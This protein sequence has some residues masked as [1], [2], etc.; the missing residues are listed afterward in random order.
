MTESYRIEAEQNEKSLK[1]KLIQEQSE[2]AKDV[3]D[4]TI[5]EYEKKII[6]L[7]EESDK[8][9][10]EYKQ[11]L[12]TQKQQLM[13]EI[14]Q[15]VEEAVQNAKREL[16]AKYETEMNEN[17]FANEKAIDVINQLNEKAIK[18][19][20]EE[21]SNEDVILLRKTKTPRGAETIRG[22]QQSDTSVDNIPS[23]ENSN[24]IN[25]EIKSTGHDNSLLHLHSVDSPKKVE[26]G[27]TTNKSNSNFEGENTDNIILNLSPTSGRTPQAWKGISL[28]SSTCEFHLKRN[29]NTEIIASIHSA[30]YDGEVKELTELLNVKQNISSVSKLNG[31]LIPIHRAITGLST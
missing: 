22:G 18:E 23:F 12:E 14:N 29:Q 25:D 11:K 31:S 4:K 7:K 28:R 16:T 27:S 20:E 6:S 9:K 19:I 13:S 8:S 26:D 21:M 1:E 10:N 15:R 5:T 30:S 3:L 24:S 17:N 2:V